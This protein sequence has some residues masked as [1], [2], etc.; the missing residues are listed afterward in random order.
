M[1]SEEYKRE[2]EAFAENDLEHNIPA[3]SQ[4]RFGFVCVLEGNY[5]GSSSGLASKNSYGYNNYFYL[6]DLLVEKEYRKKGIGTNL[7][8]LLETELRKKGIKYI[9]TWTTEYEGKEFYINRGYFQ[10]CEFKEFYF[11]GHSKIGFIKNL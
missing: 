6:S 1:T 7:L 10:F 3:E 11:T 4:E 9:W 8:N 5:I 2:L